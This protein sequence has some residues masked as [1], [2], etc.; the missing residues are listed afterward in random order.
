LRVWYWL[1]EHILLTTLFGALIVGLLIVLIWIRP[2][3][4]PA[5]ASPRPGQPSY[6]QQR[7]QMLGESQ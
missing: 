7:N 2:G 4:T 5:S 1:Q 3:P 6:A